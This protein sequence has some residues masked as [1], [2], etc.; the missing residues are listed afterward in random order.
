MIPLRKTALLAA[1]VLLIVLIVVATPAAAKPG[2]GHVEPAGNN[3]SFPVI[4]GDGSMSV[5]GTMGQA[6]LA[7]PWPSQVQYDGVLY[8]SY[9][10]KTEGNVWQAENT[11]WLS[12]DYVDDIDWGDSLESVDMKVGRP[13]RIELTLYKS[14]TDPMTG[15]VMAM[16]ANPSSPDEVQGAL[17][18]LAPTETAPVVTAALTY[19]SYEATV[20]SQNARL[21]VQP[22]IGSRE[23]IEAGDL[24]WTGTRWVD[25]DVTDLIGVED[26]QSLS[27]TG[28]LNVGGK[29]IYGLSEGGWRPSKTGD[30][31]I[32]FYLPAG[33][34]VLFDAETGIRLSAETEGM[35]ALESVVAGGTACVDWE[36]NLTYIDIRVVGGG[37]RK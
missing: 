10:Q 21:V 15:F 7:V 18:E 4:W 17:S 3:L 33:G 9:A 34:K 36:D 31:R 23:N 19:P 2:G 13:V 26:P 30:Y 20:Y 25:N 16:L 14:L 27:F 12:S 11:S 37:G 22:L 29:V 5:P 35:V 1:A 8:Y 28:E 32:T 24:V 6:S